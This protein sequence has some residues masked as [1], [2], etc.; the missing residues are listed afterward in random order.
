[1]TILRY[2]I[3]KEDGERQ[4]AGGVHGDEDEVR[5]GL[6]NQA[7]ED[8]KKNHNPDIAANPCF[9]VYIYGQDAEQGQHA[10][11]PGKN[12][13]KM[14]LDDMPPDM[15]MYKMDNPG[16]DGAFLMPAMLMMV[17]MMLFTVTRMKL[18]I[19]ITLTVRTHIQKFSPLLH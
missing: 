2:A 11:S 12:R 10:E 5:S 6:R 16:M 14:T 18:V 8:G 15:L 4:D 19:V 3:G 9:D 7:H 13:R 1:M 17:M